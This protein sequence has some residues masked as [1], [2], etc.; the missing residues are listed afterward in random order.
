[1]LPG[2]DQVRTFIVQYR[3]TIRLVRTTLKPDIFFKRLNFLFD[4]LLLLQQYESIPGMFTE[5]NPTKMLDHYRSEM[6]CIVSDFTFRYMKKVRA[7]TRTKKTMDTK[8]KY[9]ENA[10]NALISAFDCANTFWTGNGGCPHYNGP[11]FTPKNYDVVQRLWDELCD[12][13]F[14]QIRI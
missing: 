6:E 13:D 3:D 14:S 2:E 5:N 7:E 12:T 10:L 9:Y 8:E 11:L 4:I 1:M